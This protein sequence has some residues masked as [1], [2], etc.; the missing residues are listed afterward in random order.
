MSDI[1]LDSKLR[2]P[3]VGIS[4]LHV[5]PGVNGGGETFL[6]SLIDAMAD[7][8]SIG[9]LAVF[10]T[11]SNMHL[12]DSANQRI[13]LHVCRIPVGRFEVL[14]RLAWEWLALS[15]VAV[16]IGV[17]V[18][19]FA[20]NLL[21][22]VFA[23]PTVLTVCD[24]SSDQIR[25]A[26][27]D[28]IGLRLRLWYRLKLLACRWADSV[29]AIS[30]FTR[31]EIIATAKIPPD[32]VHVVPL[33]GNLEMEK[34]NKSG[35]R[36]LLASPRYVLFVGSQNRQKNVRRLVAAFS[37]LIQSPACDYDL[38]I[39][40]NRAETGLQVARDI[41]EMG[42]EKRVHQLGF[43]SDDDLAVLYD[44]AAMMVLPSTY[45]GF[46]MPIVEAFRKGIPVALSD[47]PVF[48]EVAG[49]AGWFFDPL[50][51]EDIA[52][53][54]STLMNDEDLRSELV[55]KGSDRAASFSWERSA[56]AMAAVYRLAGESR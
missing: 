15:R 17:D 7:C 49:D 18:M 19:H 5:R 24:L 21:P 34:V 51:V 42:M 50:S 54:I 26:R 46:G 8:E 33:S 4:A 28:R 27:W 22:P 56:K 10:V 41:A 14:F 13:E 47:I 1:K 40:G 11:P 23:T 3:V 30:D 53:A 48:R 32:R 12:F 38:V 9:K 16:R 44:N 52:G 20:G 55:Q 2:E 39:A 35:S 29:V 36:P 6:R 37:R 43:V 31:D 25:D 45:E